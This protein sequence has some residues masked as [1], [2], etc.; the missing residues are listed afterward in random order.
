MNFT[1]GFIHM[2]YTHAEQTIEDLR[3]RSTA[4]ES[5]IRSLEQKVMQLKNSWVGDDADVYEDVQKRWNAAVDNINTLLRANSVL[6]NDIAERYRQS[7]RSGAQRWMGVGIG[8][9]F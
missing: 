2:N 8:R 7:E 6:L 5:A 1:D 3:S 9:T 4:I